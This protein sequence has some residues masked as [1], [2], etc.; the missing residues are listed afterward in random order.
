MIKD[1]CN[2]MERN[3]ILKYH[4]EGHPVEVIAKELRLTERIVKSIISHYRPDSGVEA[5]EPVK[6]KVED[7]PASKPKKK[8]KKKVKKK[9]KKKSTP[10][11][12]FDD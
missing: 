4:D 1:G 7:K 2:N 12:D 9:A 3:K 8:A 5:D 11:D 6:A 10:A